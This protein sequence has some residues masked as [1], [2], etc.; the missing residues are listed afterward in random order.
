MKEVVISKVYFDTN[1]F[2][3]IYKKIGVTETDLQVLWNAVTE[4]RL[5]IIFS[6]I[7]IEE[8]LAALKS[9][10]AV[11]LHELWLILKRADWERI[12]KPTDILL[13]EAIRCYARGQDLTSPFTTDP[14]I[15]V[16]LERLK[17][18]T[19]RDLD[20]FA[21]TLEEVAKQKA[22]FLAG[23]RAA[24]STW[25]ESVLPQV[26]ELQGERPDFNRYWEVSAESLAEQLAERIGEGEACRARGIRGLLEVRSVRLAVGANL[27]LIYSQTFGGRG[28][29]KG[30]S[31]DI[32]HAILA[33]AADAFVTN[34]STFGGLVA[35]IP[36]QGFQVTDLR[37]LLREIC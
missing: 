5:S 16:G 1:V 32:Q 33:A 36:M 27:S 21:P 2:D 25:M 14:W 4:G 10:P 18:P 22:E 24:R 37:G 30:D 9:K 7:N 12:V 34:D 13:T 28:P 8:V 3:H 23:M 31:R 17:D 20:E 26:R 35:R 19:Q 11:A 29:D 6:V 15:K